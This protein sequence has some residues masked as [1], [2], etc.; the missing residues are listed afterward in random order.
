MRPDITAF[1]QFVWGD[2]DQFENWPQTLLGEDASSI[3]IDKANTKRIYSI[4]DARDPY[5]PSTKNHLYTVG[6]ALYENNLY[7]SGVKFSPYHR[8]TM[9]HITIP[10]VDDNNKRLGFLMVS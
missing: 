2:S 4:D 10:R 9:K 5:K 3:M 7:I 1:Q 8:I 6:N